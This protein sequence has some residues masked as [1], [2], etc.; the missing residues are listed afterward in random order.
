MSQVVRAATLLRAHR[1]QDSRPGVPYRLTTPTQKTVA[2][3]GE[4]MSVRTPAMKSS[5]QGTTAIARCEST[6]L[7]RVQTPTS[8]KTSEFQRGRTTHH[9]PPLHRMVRT[10]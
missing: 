6:L 9:S 8:G 4:A 5:G 1:Q 2:M 10:G 3:L 7:K